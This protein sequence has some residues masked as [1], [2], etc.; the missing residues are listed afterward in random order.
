MAFFSIIVPIYNVELYLVDCLNSIL[1]QTYKTFEVILVDD[2]STDNC[3]SICD[4]YALKDDRIKVIHKENGGLVSARKAGVNI[5]SGDYALCVDSDDWK[6]KYNFLKEESVEVV[7]IPRS[8][9]IR[10][11]QI[12]KVLFDANAVDS[13]NKASHNN[14][15]RY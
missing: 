8:P 2:G 6:G 9:E 13:E 7:Y 12:K 15:L 10:S 5:A 11:S 14:M 1:D 4:E 3:A